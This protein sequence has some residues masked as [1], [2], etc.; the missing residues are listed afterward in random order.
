MRSLELVNEGKL[1]DAIR[2]AK[3]GVKSSP[4]DIDKRIVLGK[5]LCFVGDF[6]KADLH[7]ETALMQSPEMAYS[8]SHDRYLIRASIARKKWFTES[9]LP[10]FIAPIDP[11]VELQL[12]FWTLHRA[13]D[14]EQAL[15]ILEH[16]NDYCDSLSG[17]SDGSPFMGFRDLDDSTIACLEVLSLA[18]K[19]F[20][21]PW[22]RI[23][24][25]EFEP[26]K[27]LGDLLWREAHVVVREG[28][29]TNIFVPVCY[30][31]T[32]AESGDAALLGRT[33]E[34][35]NMACGTVTGVGHR[36]FRVA[37]NDIPILSIKKLEFSNLQ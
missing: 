13:G 22:H 32:D 26:P 34:W 7:L 24:S 12:K 14:A 25:L 31:G 19:Y 2:D 21:I 5:L 30:P 17:V 6:E 8:I 23:E 18:G 11:V 20:W 28:P 33:T 10:D 35:L 37:D 15:K 1:M 4:T 29:D 16:L 27:K 36:I 3:D 9:A